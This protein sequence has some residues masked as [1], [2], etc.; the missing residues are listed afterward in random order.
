MLQQYPGQ[1]YGI[2]AITISHA[3]RSSDPWALNLRS[4]RLRALRM[5]PPLI[6]IQS[7]LKNHNSAI[8][9]LTC[10]AT[11]NSRYNELPLWPRR[12]G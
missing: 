5:N 11:M 6:R 2:V 8:S 10:K 4:R 3:S 7:A 1:A 12:I 9:V